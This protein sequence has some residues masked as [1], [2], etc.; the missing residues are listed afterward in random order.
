MLSPVQRSITLQACELLHKKGGKAG[1]ATQDTPQLSA[2]FHVGQ[3][4]RC[5]VV[6]LQHGSGSKG[7]RG[8]QHCSSCAAG[9]KIIA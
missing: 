3:F 2:L 6:G 5:V 1:M 4:V 9:L 7:G 8:E